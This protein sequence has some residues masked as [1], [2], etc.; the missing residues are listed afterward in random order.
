VITILKIIYELN[1]N[2][3]TDSLIL[4][5]NLN[6]KN[7]KDG[8][9]IFQRRPSSIIQKQNINVSNGK[10]HR[11][12]YSMS[13]KLIIPMEL[14]IIICSSTTDNQSSIL[15]LKIFVAINLSKKS[16]YV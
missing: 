8:V 1:I 3:E 10:F 11:L 13:V 15:P 16:P 12:K 6:V 4:N 7:G 2:S 14:S 9:H 5:E